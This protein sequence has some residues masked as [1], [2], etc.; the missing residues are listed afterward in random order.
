MGGETRCECVIAREC[1]GCLFDSHILRGDRAASRGGRPD[2]N[3][4]FSIFSVF[5]FS[6]SMV[7]EVKRRR[8]NGARRSTA[9]QTAV[10]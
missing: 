8:E 1:V 5:F 2:R 4:F 6:S 10:D 3:P 9:G 7:G